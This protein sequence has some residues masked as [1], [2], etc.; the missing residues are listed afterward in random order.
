M[1]YMP[2]NQYSI[3]CICFGWLCWT[4]E[5]RTSSQTPRQNRTETPTV[6]SRTPDWDTE[7]CWKTSERSWRTK[8]THPHWLQLTSWSQK[9]WR[10]EKRWVF[11]R[12]Q[13]LLPPA[14]CC[15]GDAGSWS[16]ACDWSRAQ[17]GRRW[18][19]SGGTRR[20]RSSRRT[21]WVCCSAK[22]ER[23]RP[24]RLLQLNTT[25]AARLIKTI[26]RKLDLQQERWSPS[27]RLNWAE[28]GNICSVG[29]VE[30]AVMLFIKIN[31]DFLHIYNHNH[32]F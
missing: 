30:R 22:T 1:L 21:R 27:T 6:Q 26:C 28:G 24:I 9:H 10:A 17:R 15:H 25:S 12:Q 4:A 7:N 11:I 14:S 3:F 20:P 31:D 29:G 5:L 2:C 32:W 8:Q 18:R 19:E 13:V 16:E 23:Q